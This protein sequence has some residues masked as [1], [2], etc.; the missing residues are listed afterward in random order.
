[1]NDS[2]LHTLSCRTCLASLN[3]HLSII[4]NYQPVLQSLARHTPQSQGKTDLVTMR[5]TSCTGDKMLS[6]PIRFEI[7]NLLLS[8]TLLVAHV[9]SW[10]CNTLQ[11]SVTFFVTIAFC[12]NNLLYARSPDPYSLEIEGAGARDYFSPSL[13]TRPLSPQR[14]VLSG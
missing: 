12:T 11:L 4:M 7:L 14:L 9:H 13:K 8:N 6:R 10:P 5:T 1:M 2:L 3:S